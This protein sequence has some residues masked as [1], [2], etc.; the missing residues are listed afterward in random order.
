MGAQLERLFATVDRERVHVIFY[1]DFRKQLPVVYQR[2]VNF[3][4][5]PDDGRVEFPRVNPAK[6]YRSE[7]L[8][9]LVVQPP[10]PLSVVKS[11]LKER[12]GWKETS[13][14]RWIYARITVPKRPAP[15][16]DELRA[17]L[18]HYFGEDVGL[19]AELTGKNLDHWLC[20]RSSPPFDRRTTASTISR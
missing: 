19:L 10:Y 9:R 16:S 20:P 13:V 7:W 15:L 18:S 12:L 14:G 2:V 11:Q 1:D 4:G 8:A 17:E 3:L 5:L 6:A